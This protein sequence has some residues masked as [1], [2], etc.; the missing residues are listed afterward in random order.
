MNL[1]ILFAA[2]SAIGAAVSAFFSYRA[3]SESR[4]NIFLRE[5]NKVAHAVR[6]IKRDFDTQWVGYKISAHLEDQGSLLSAKYFVEPSLYEKFTSVLV[7]LHQL[8]RKL[9]FEGATDELA[10]KIANE[11][12]G[13][14]CSMRLDQ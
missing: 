10:E 8:E 3:I 4:K 14:T 13:I 5:K 12:D 9:S 7:H 6:K 1:E 11:L 2:V